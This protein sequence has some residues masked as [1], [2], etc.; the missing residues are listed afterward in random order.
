MRALTGLKEL[1]L[2]LQP[3]YLE[4]VQKALL[5]SFPAEAEGQGIQD[6]C[7]SSVTSLTLQTPDWLSLSPAFPNL[8]KLEIR[9]ASTGHCTLP[10]SDLNFAALANLHPNLITLH[11][12]A[13]G[14]TEV[15]QGTH[16]LAV[17]SHVFANNG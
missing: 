11:C 17:T 16:S 2:L 6:N 9:L 7:L 14:T 5:H 10:F 4:Q 8:S 3:Q 15:V 12:H 13:P 1:H